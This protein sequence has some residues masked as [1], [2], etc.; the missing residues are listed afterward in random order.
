MSEIE[1]SSTRAAVRLPTAALA[2]A[3]RW[4]SA[5]CRMG[6]VGTRGSPSTPCL[7]ASCAEGLEKRLAGGSRRS[8]G[9][10]REMNAESGLRFASVRTRRNAPVPGPAVPPQ[11]RRPGEDVKRCALRRGLLPDR[12]KPH[13]PIRTRLRTSC[14]AKPGYRTPS[15]RSL[16]S[17]VGEMAT[18]WCR[19]VSPTPS[20]AV[21]R[22][23]LLA[24]VETLGQRPP[25]TVDHLPQPG[26]QQRPQAPCAS[27]TSSPTRCAT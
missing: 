27:T 11:G 3:H 18:R 23:R 7:K 14:L 5:C 16:P 19:V 2:P 4:R 24:D 25:A 20:P 26:A 10:S 12:D 13:R 6:N 9:P 21:P 17:K 1:E 15:P 22:L 8:A